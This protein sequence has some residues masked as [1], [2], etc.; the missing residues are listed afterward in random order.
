MRYQSSLTKWK[1]ERWE[2]MTDDEL[3]RDVMGE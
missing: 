3:R 2:G 1:R